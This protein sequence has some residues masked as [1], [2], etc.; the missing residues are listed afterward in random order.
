MVVSGYYEV[1]FE[2]FIELHGSGEGLLGW[3]M[4]DFKV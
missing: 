3:F 1:R 4:V 2:D